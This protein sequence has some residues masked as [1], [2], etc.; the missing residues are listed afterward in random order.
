V[1]HWYKAL[2]ER[3]QNARRKACPV[4]LRLKFRGEKPSIISP[5]MARLS[6]YAKL[7]CLSLNITLLTST[8]LWREASLILSTIKYI[9]LESV[10][11]IFWSNS[12]SDFC[13][14]SQKSMGRKEVI[15]LLR[16]V[17]NS[18]NREEIF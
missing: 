6:Q 9:R 17:H 15:L 14:S 18:C 3:Y 7:Q 4:S 12:C 5:S 16:E 1:Q 13:C 10:G 11:G 8:D 2:T